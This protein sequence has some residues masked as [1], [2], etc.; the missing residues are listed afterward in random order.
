MTTDIASLIVVFI[1]GSG[2]RIP[3]GVAKLD[4]TSTV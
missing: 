4:A 2:M 1:F 3:D